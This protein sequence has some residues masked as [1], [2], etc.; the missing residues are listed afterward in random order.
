MKF[1]GAY[2]AIISLALFG[3]ALIVMLFGPY[4][5]TP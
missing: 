4:A 5:I 1:R 2:E 3:L